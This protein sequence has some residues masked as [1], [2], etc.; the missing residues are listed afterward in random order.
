MRVKAEA[1]QKELAALD[2]YRKQA[3]GG[4]F[5]A[6]WSVMLQ[7]LLRRGWVAD[8]VRSTLA[9]SGRDGYHGKLTPAGLAVLHREDVRKLKA[10]KQMPLFGEGSK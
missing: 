1:T 2:G 8:V 7:E 9:N 4:R 3:K 5:I 10:A 6:C